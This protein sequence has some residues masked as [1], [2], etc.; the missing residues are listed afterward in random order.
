MCNHVSQSY[1]A[2][3]DVFAYIIW[4]KEQEDETVSLLRIDWLCG[5]SRVVAQ[6][7]G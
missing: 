7:L 1:Y 3:A 6:Q 4:R 2:Q 5:E